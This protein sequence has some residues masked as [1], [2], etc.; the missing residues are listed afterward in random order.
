MGK[1]RLPPNSFELESLRVSPCV[2]QLCLGKIAKK[3]QAREGI[4]PNFNVGDAV[5]IRKTGS[6]AKIIG[7]GSLALPRADNTT[8]LI[9]PEGGGPS[10]TVLPEEI[11][12]LKH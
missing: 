10:V 2:R 11:E 9:Q 7:K 8:W 5:R 6:T 12:P 4:M 3:G 1:T